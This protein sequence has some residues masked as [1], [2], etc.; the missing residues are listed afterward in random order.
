VLDE[1]RLIAKLGF[2][3]MKKHRRAGIN[4]IMKY[5]YGNDINSRTI[6][7]G[8]APRINASGRIGNPHIAFKLLTTED[9]EMADKLAKELD[10][11]NVR[12]QEIEHKILEEA[13]NLV[14]KDARNENVIVLSSNEWN[15]GVIGIVSSKL[16]DKYYRPTFL[17][18]YD[19]ESGMGRGSAR[20]VE[21][22]HLVEIING[23][24]DLVESFGGHEFAAG[25][26]IK[27]ENIDKFH[28]RLYEVSKQK[29]SEGYPPSSI[30]IDM[31]L[32]PGDINIRFYDDIYDKLYP[33]GEK[34]PFPVFGLKNLTV[35]SLTLFNQKHAS[36]WLTDGINNLKAVYYN[37][38]SNGNSDLKINKGDNIDVV[39]TMKLSYLKGE[40]F[41]ELQ[42][43]DIYSEKNENSNDVCTKDEFEKWK[44]RG[45]EYFFSGSF[46]RAIEFYFKALKIAGS[47]P[48]VNFNIGLA[49]F[50]KGDKGKAIYYYN[51]ALKFSKNNDDEVYNKAFT[52]LKKIKNAG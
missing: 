33:F 27:K 39:F 49:Y 47:D 30:N 34:N 21:G 28:T 52:G 31:F 5:V 51:K 24:S 6:S 46:D 9:N 44:E 23:M 3:I 14:E 17:I 7:F 42:L 36:F 10:Y 18:S 4:S 16:K 48:R 38:V 26:T 8:I 20:S 50:K 11:Q 19:R 25:F 1:N 12:R 37:Y 29:F 43:L 15:L 35:N 32:E 13:E 40:S 41:L 2:D 22:F 45:N